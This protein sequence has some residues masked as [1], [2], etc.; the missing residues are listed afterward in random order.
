MTDRVIEIR[1]LAP[2]PN[3]LSLLAQPEFAILRDRDSAP[4]RSSV[5]T[6]GTGGELRL[7]RE[8]AVGDEE[9]SRREEVLLAGASA[10]DAI[11]DFAGDKVDLVLGGTFA[12]LP[13]A[14]RVKLPRNAL[15]IRPG[16]GP[17]RAGP[18][19]QRRPL[20]NPDVRRLLAQALDRANFI[21]ALG[22]PG[23]AAAR[24]PARAGPRR[25]PGTSR[26]SV[27]R[28]AARR[29]AARARDAGA[30]A[31]FGKDKPVI[32]VALPDGPGA[33][34]LLQELRPRLGRDR[35]HGRARRD[36]ACLPISR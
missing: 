2:R 33:D 25:H 17:V 6:G 32:R 34:L 7:T 9:Q 3:L 14:Q 35:P 36:P 22:V 26:S 11:R 29:P 20:D 1:L 8:I 31:L 13:L 21:D 5:T 15:A 24:D 16:V 4:A 19:A 30:S 23:L 27:A 18:G 10:A 12:D 28:H